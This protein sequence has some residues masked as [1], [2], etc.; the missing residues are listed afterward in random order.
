MIERGKRVPSIDM[1]E[2]IAD[3]FQKEPEWFLDDEPNRQI[4]SH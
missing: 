2:V 1:L 4:S 3:V